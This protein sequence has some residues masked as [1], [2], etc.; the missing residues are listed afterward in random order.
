MKKLMLKLLKGS[1]SEGYNWQLALES[2]EFRVL[3][4]NSKAGGSF[5][6]GWL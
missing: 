4:Y 5:Y 6:K 2:P 3:R 1:Q